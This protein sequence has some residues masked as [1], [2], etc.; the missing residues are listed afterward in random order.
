MVHDSDHTP[1]DYVGGFRLERLL[2]HGVLGSTYVAR[3]GS[4]RRAALKVIHPGWGRPQDVGEMIRRSVLRPDGPAETSARRRHPRGTFL[5]PFDGGHDEESGRAWVATDL[6]LPDGGAADGRYARRAV[7]V[8]AA[9]ALAGVFQAGTALSMLS[10]LAGLADEL[11]TEGL[12]LVG[13]K[14][15]NVFLTD[16]GVVVVDVHLAQ[17]LR[18]LLQ[19]ARSPRGGLEGSGFTAFVWAD[20]AHLPPELRT[21]QGDRQLRASSGVYA[22][23]AVTLYACVERSLHPGYD[24]L[25]A[26]MQ[27]QRDRVTASE[28]LRAWVSEKAGARGYTTGQLIL[29]GL[30]RRGW[31]RPGAR[32]LGRLGR[33]GGPWRS[34]TAACRQAWEAYVKQA[35]ENA[36]QARSPAALAN[37]RAP[38]ALEAGNTTVPG[39]AESGPPSA[40]RPTDEHTLAK[41]SAEHTSANPNSRTSADGPATPPSHTPLGTSANAPGTPH[42]PDAGHGPADTGEHMAPG[43]GSPA[44]TGTHAAS[45]TQPDPPAQPDPRRRADPCTS[46]AT[47]PDPRTP[48]ATEPAR[49]TDAVPPPSGHAPV[50]VGHVPST[51]HGAVHQGAAAA[52]PPP[53]AS[54]ATPATRSEG[55]DHT[56]RLMSADSGAADSGAAGARGRS[57]R[58]RRALPSGASTPRCLWQFDT[59]EPLL[60][61]PLAYRDALLVVSGAFLHVLCPATGT[62][63]RH[64][65]EGTAEAPPVAFADLLWFAFR[66]GVLAGVDPGTGEHKV[67]VPFAGDPGSGAPVVLGDTLWTGTSAGVLHG[68]RP[69]ADG[70]V[71][72]VPVGEPVVSTPLADG[73]VL[74]VPTGRN[75]LV[76]VDVWTDERLL[77]ALPWDAAGCT[78][79]ANPGHGV[80]VGGA[81]GRVRCHRR[82]R[83]QPVWVRDLIRSPVTAPL[84]RDGDLLLATD[85]GGTVFALDAADGSERWHAASDGDGSTAVAVQG[86]VVHVAGARD[87][88]RLSREDGR[89]LDPWNVGGL[90]SAAPVAAYGRLYVS[91][92]DGV[93]LAYGTAD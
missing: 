65:L 73:T 50:P 75:G 29:H 38:L 8:D 71:R 17:V 43:T 93:L 11:H 32:G 44:N 61:A 14:P 59:R 1:L 63:R 92:A 22:A 12:S 31:R 41:A 24:V 90:Q 69:L 53:P 78:P 5:A 19:G 88:L 36:S 60:A 25:D 40:P 57:A 49:H 26:V 10:Q 47:A 64:L 45:C 46:S 89:A 6:L 39:A 18:P 74:W 42:D 23:A 76:G 68:F 81:D 9:V 15:S 79:V 62:N 86:G 66:E 84:V 37:G 20:T 2:G 3:A 13:L 30:R 67:V 87:L 80:C 33:R 7:A 27:P 28:L 58:S 72:T 48:T 35:L 85:H 4:G 34:R 56:V 52:E 77:P 83:E 54:T 21:A 51:G 91:L 82:S 16:D 55:S 70:G